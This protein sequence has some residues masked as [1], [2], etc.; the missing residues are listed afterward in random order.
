ML[1]LLSLKN[2]IINNKKGYTITPTVN[3]LRSLKVLLNNMYAVRTASGS[4]CS[5]HSGAQYNGKISLRGMNEALNNLKACSCNNRTVNATTCSCNGRTS[6][7]N[8]DNYSSGCSSVCT[9]NSRTNSVCDC[10]DRTGV[11]ESIVDSDALGCDS[12][13]CDSVVPCSCKSTYGYIDCLCY[14]RTGQPIC[15]CNARTNENGEWGSTSP[16]GCTSQIA[17]GCDCQGRTTCSCNT[18]NEF[19]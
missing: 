3:S 15:T 18:V 1:S 7:C 13:G 16:S 6:G 8:C 14:T 19:N 2:I 11:P 17:S 5:G 12:V 10:Q 9:C 4:Y